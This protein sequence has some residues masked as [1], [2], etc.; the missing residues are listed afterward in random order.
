MTEL[1]LEVGWSFHPFSLFTFPLLTDTL[2]V[3]DIR[4]RKYKKTNMS[5][6]LIISPASEQTFRSEIL[7]SSSM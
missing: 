7:G 2:Y 1:I 4:L 5:Q 3:V 6:H